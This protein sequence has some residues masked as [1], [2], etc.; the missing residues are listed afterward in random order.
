MITSGAFS[1]NYRLGKSSEFFSSFYPSFSKNSLDI[2]H[3]MCKLRMKFSLWQSIKLD[4]KPTYLGA[5]RQF[6]SHPKASNDPCP[7][8]KDRHLLP[9]LIYDSCSTNRKSLVSDYQFQIVECVQC[10]SR[11]WVTN[12]SEI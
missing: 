7:I 6:Y 4:L 8:D 12:E 5:I 1:G 11:G 10:T 2:L 3:G 9:F